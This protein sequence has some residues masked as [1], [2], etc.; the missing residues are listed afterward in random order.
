MQR[1]ALLS[2][3]YYVVVISPPCTSVQY[4]SYTII[5]IVVVEKLP[6][7]DIPIILNIFN[8]LRRNVEPPASN[9][10]ELVSV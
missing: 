4:I 8:S 2:S 6:D 9:M 10:Q 5:V 1:D 7:S 3:D